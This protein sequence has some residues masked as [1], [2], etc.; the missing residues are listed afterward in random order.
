MAT[1][2][3]ATKLDRTRRKL[4][5]LDELLERMLALPLAPSEESAP[6][7]SG[8]AKSSPLPLPPPLPPPVPTPEPR[9]RFALAPVEP[10]PVHENTPPPLVPV[11]QDLGMA[12]S[13]VTVHYADAVAG[14]NVQFI[15]ATTMHVPPT[16]AAPAPPP[17][18]W[19]AL[20]S[21]RNGAGVLG[22]LSF[23]LAVVLW[24]GSRWGWTR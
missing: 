16:A 2:T 12:G 13:M 4:R 21:V 20:P 10:V 1:V 8:E 14:D 24:L 11:D 5:E 6:P 7:P 15:P 22:I 3:E 18:P 9:V 17:T 23:V 19:W